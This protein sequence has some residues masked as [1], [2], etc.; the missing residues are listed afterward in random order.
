MS[1]RATSIALIVSVI[2]YIVLFTALSIACHEAFNAAILD[3][4]IMTQ[5]TWNTTLTIFMG[6]ARTSKSTSASPGPSTGPSRSLRSARVVLRRNDLLVSKQWRTEASGGLAS[7]TL[8]SCVPRRGAGSSSE[9]PPSGC[10]PAGLF[11]VGEHAIP[12]FRAAKREV[13]IRQTP[14]AR[15]PFADHRVGR[16]GH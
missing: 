13:V 4:G 14:A 3:L 8:G 10:S 5:V 11:D 16:A 2:I 15:K 12:R 1:H 6:F 7:P 9:R